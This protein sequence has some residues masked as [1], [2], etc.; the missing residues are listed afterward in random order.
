M[1]GDE[2]VPPSVT[3]SDGHVSIGGGA[4]VQL[5]AVSRINVD[6][7][8]SAVPPETVG[9]WLE[10]NKRYFTP[11]QAE[12][13]AEDFQSGKLAKGVLGA[14]GFVLGDGDYTRFQSAQDIAVPASSHDQASF[15]V[16]LR[17]LTNSPLRLTSEIEVEGTSMTSTVAAVFARVVQIHFGDGRSANFVDL[18]DPVAA[19]ITGAVR[20]VRAKKSHALRVVPRK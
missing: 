16:A 3:I 18:S 8:I 5:G 20:G 14:L 2:A 1:N 4:S 19:D 12:R 15:I 13:L 6:F 10:H 9:I 17:A 11:E 7:A